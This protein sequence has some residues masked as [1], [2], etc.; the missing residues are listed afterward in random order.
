MSVAVASLV[1]EGQAWRDERVG[2]VWRDER[3]GNVRDERWA[4]VEG[5]RVMAVWRDERVASV[6]G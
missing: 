1:G 4:S 2:Q 5:Y 6:E 3:V